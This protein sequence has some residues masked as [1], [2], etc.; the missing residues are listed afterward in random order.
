MSSARH[1][2]LYRRADAC[3]ATYNNPRNTYDPDVW[4]PQGWAR[5]NNVE[6]S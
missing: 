6:P 3:A 2:E 4:T 1:D 5:A